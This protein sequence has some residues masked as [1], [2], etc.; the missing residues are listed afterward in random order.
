[1]NPNLIKKVRS[2][3]GFLLGTLSENIYASYGGVVGAMLP[4]G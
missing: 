3:R 4:L 1:M 2:W